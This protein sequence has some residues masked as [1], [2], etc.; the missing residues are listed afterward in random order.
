MKSLGVWYTKG[1]DVVD[2][3]N[4]TSL[5][6][7]EISIHAPFEPMNSHFVYDLPGQHHESCS[8]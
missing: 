5:Q 8:Q 2:P 3:V 6:W 7:H 4:E 1:I